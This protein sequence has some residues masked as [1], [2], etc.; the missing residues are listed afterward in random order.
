MRK[1]IAVA[2]FVAA[3]A[4]SL[5]AEL[6]YT[7]RMQLKPSTVPAA[8]P[9]P[10]LAAIGGL[11]MEMIVPGGSSEITVITGERGTRIEANKGLIGMPKGGV[12]LQRPDG[13]IVGIDHAS[14]TY[15]K[16]GVPDMAGIQATSKRTGE[17]S[18]MAGE[19]VERVTFRIELPLGEAMKSI[20]PIVIEGDAWVAERFKKYTVVKGVKPGALGL[21]QLADL[22][23]SLRQIMRSRMFGDKE[24][25]SVATDVRED[26]APASLFEIPAGYKEV[27]GPGKIGR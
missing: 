15:W 1:L 22:G 11:V 6:R 21:F 19:K 2:L 8:A 23:L 17:V 4:A 5:Q 14:K 16:S 13:S 20:S 3:S 12:M 26:P 18:T 27:P 7:L 24:I 25:E 9:D 10:N